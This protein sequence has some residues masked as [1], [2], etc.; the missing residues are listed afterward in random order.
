[1]EK[2]DSRKVAIARRLRSETAVSLR[3]IAD[4]LEMGSIPYLAKLIKKG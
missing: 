4:Q 2:S 3:W 1:M